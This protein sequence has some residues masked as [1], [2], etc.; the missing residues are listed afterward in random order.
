MN[1]KVLKFSQ[2]HCPPCRIL[3]NILINQQDIRDIDTRLE[4]E[5]AKE[6]N[7]KSTPTLVFLKDDK[8]VHR[9]SG[10]IPL[11]TYLE[12]IDEIKFSKELNN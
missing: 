6:Y 8:E 7:I 12:I 1:I 3:S 5:L 2:S 4:P 11:S 10:T 9:S